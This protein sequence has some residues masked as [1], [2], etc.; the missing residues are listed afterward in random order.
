MQNLSSPKENSPFYWTIHS[1]EC[2]GGDY[3]ES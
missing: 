2:G 3:N 1:L